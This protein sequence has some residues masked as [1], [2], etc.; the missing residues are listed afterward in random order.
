MLKQRLDFPFEKE[1]ETLDRLPKIQGQNLVEKIKYLL[2]NRIFMFYP[3]GLIA[4]YS[5]V[6]LRDTG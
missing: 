4:C 6:V 5:H 2:A 3:S 1:I